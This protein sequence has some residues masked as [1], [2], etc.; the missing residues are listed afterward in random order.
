MSEKTTKAINYAILTLIAI[1]F[2]LPL[3]WLVL[4]ALDSGANQA[5]KWPT[6]WTLQNFIDVLK[7][8]DNLRGFGVGLIISV[9]QSFVVVLVSGLAAYPLSRYHLSY[10]KP[11]M[12]II[13]FMTALPMIA[14]IVP[15]YKMFLNIGLLDS[16]PGVILY[17]TA[18]SLP[19][20]IWLMKNFMD[21]VPVELEE[22]AWVD[23]ATTMTSIRK[24]VAPLMFPGICVVFI[25]TFSG[26]WG[27][28]FVPYILLSSSNK[29]PASVMLY[30][31]FGQ[32]GSIAYGTLAAYSII[33]AL[34][35][36][37]LYVLSQ[38][39]MSK[40]FTMAGA[41]KG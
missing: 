19:Y 31:F 8:S 2:V 30:Q 25:Y 35:S 32:H 15:I 40:G 14:V 21:G 27:N 4:A 11:F 22:A 3:I 36:I 26:S 23:G 5:L 17:L 7:S 38:N 6:T 16:I 34:P 28:F 10:K 37:L 18:S 41:A 39:Y 33:Y 24:V 12:Y 20:G 29:L 13:L 9:I 1:L